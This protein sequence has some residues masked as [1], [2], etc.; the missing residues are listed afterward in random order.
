MTQ[1]KG[2]WTFPAI[3]ALVIAAIFFAAFWDKTKVTGDEAAE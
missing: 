1:W 2:F 3:M